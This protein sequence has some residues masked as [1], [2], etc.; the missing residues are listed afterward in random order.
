MDPS[1]QLKLKCFMGWVGPGLLSPV[2]LSYRKIIKFWIILQKKKK[3]GRWRYINKAEGFHHTTR[4]K[5][6]S[7]YI[8]PPNPENEFDAVIN[9]ELVAGADNK[10]RCRQF[11]ISSLICPSSSSWCL[12]PRQLHRS[13]LPLLPSP[14]RRCHKA[15]AQTESEMLS[16]LHAIDRT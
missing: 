16:G 8:N 3:S 7:V 1:T 6:W 2:Q 12:D 14:G 4:R 10:N 13:R 5:K 15:T 9:T 11:L